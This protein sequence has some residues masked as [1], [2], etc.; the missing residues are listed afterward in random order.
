MTVRMLVALGLVLTLQGA[1][2]GQPSDT[3]PAFDVADVHVRAP[4]TN[5][6]PP[7]MTG[8]LLRSSRYDLRNATMLD[9]IRTAYGVEPDTIVGGPNWL[10]RDRFDIV[11]KAPQE[12]SADTLRLMLQALLADRFKLVV[13]KDTK[14]IPGYAL[15]LGKGKPKLRESSG[16]GEGCQP[17]PSPPPQPGSI[18]NVLVTC[19][20]ITMQA[21]A[22]A[23]RRMAGAY[24]SSP[25]TDQTGLKGSWDFELTWTARA[26]LPMAGSDGISIFDAVDR[27]LGLKLELQK[28]PAS[29]LVV[30][31]VNQRPTD[32]PS[33][34]AQS[35]PAPP[36]A[37]FDVADIKLSPPDANG[38]RGRLQPGGR[39]DLEG[40]PLKMLI[41]LAWGINDDE[42]LVGLP[43]WAESVK[44]NIIAK[45]TTAVSGTPNAPQID[46]DDVQLMMRALLI[47]RF[48]LATHFED[49]QVTAYTLVADKP[50]LTKAD[51]ANRT[52][53]KEGPAPDAKDTRIG[54]LTR[55]V[56]AKNMTMAQLAED[57]PRMAGGYIHTAVLDA[58]G[59]DGAY[60]FTLT[61]SPIGLLMGGGRGGRGDAPAGAGNS[62]APAALDPSGGLSLF[63]AVSK[64]LGLKL[65]KGKRTLPV[66][67]IDHVEKPTDE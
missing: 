37:E 36:P 4:S 52:N 66:L 5:P 33:G 29:V 39:I 28:A 56:T 2:F 3:P 16:Q 24:L 61:F 6:Q 14:P 55:M 25:V 54:T 19:R 45:S 17:Q 53:W 57:L 60:D 20:N 1:L 58:T 64:Q 11:A 12:T 43:N 42:M 15:S 22:E 31:S 63:D 23:V 21:F 44:F 7:F 62:N 47:E 67:V 8:G 26:A 46:F 65:E 35:L 48:K 30:D 40:F 50:K 10:E 9:L 34:I 51:P 38:M 41:N 59:L 49:R 32:N 13:H 18:P 27:Q